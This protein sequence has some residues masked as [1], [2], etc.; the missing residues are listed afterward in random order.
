[1]YVASDCCC[2]SGEPEPPTGLQRVNATHNTL[3]LMWTAGFDGGSEQTFQ[4][5]YQ[6]DGSDDNT[7]HYQEAGDETV[8]TVG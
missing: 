3:T 6:E 1:M 4:V 5:R 7:I 8:Y 2:T